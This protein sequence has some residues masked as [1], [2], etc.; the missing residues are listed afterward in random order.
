MYIEH[1]K[2]IFPLLNVWS[3]TWSTHGKSLTEFGKSRSLKIINPSKV[4]EKNWASS[5]EES[6]AFLQAK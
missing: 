6:S 3:L 4:R 2:I 1:K 5:P